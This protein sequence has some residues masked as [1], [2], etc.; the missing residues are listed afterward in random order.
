M[1]GVCTYMVRERKN[2]LTYLICD[3]IYDIVVLYQMYHINLTIQKQRSCIINPLYYSFLNEKKF[4][5]PRKCVYAA[6]YF[7]N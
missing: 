4:F 2:G 7:K 1:A 3:I 5:S 6:T